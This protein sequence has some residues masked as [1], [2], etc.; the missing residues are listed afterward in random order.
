M[1]KDGPLYYQDGKYIRDSNKKAALKCLCNL[2][3]SIDSLINDV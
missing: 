3:E 1:W 2:Q